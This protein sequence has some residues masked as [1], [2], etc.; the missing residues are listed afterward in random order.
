[1][2]FAKITGFDCGGTAV[3]TAIKFIIGVLDVIFVLLPILL[4]LLLVID[5]IKNIVA[6][7]EDEMKKNKNLLIKRIIVCVILF[8]VEPITHFVINN[9]A[10][11]EDNYLACIKIAKETDDL[12]QYEI[13]VPEVE[14]KE[15]YSFFDNKKKIVAPK[16]E[17]KKEEQTGGEEDTDTS[18]A[19]SGSSTFDKITQNE[20]EVKKAKDK[21]ISKKT[22][23][24]LTEKKINNK[25]ISVF[26]IKITDASQLGQIQA[27]DKYGSGV[28]TITSMV[29]RKTSK[30]S[31]KKVILAVTGAFFKTSNGAQ[32]IA[33]FKNNFGTTDGIVIQN[34]K[35]V[36]DN[37]SKKAWGYE[38]CQDN[39][40]RLFYAKKGESAESLIKKGVMNTF[41]SHEARGIDN[42]KYIEPDSADNNRAYARSY[43]A[44][45]KPGEYYVVQ[46][47]YDVTRA[48]ALS[49]IKD[50]LKCS[51][52][53][54]LE[55]GGA[56]ASVTINKTIKYHS[57]YTSGIG[58]A[59]VITE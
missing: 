53:G 59:F 45:K 48:E 52:A 34:G 31:G 3:L 6:G 42:G 2:S 36:E 14:N 55:Q 37:G 33:A 27:N 8:L 57:G 58:D 43:L 10:A 12:S 7:S 21:Y 40:G 23:M 24:V 47:G 35:L 28:E 1:M 20:K 50:K 41:A 4:T 39:K 11:K 18:S 13:K 17:E 38:I 9:A 56:V 16:K 32:N 25:T 22:Y 51:F 54:S 29:K 19:D 5:I 30:S 49:Y 46:I 26:H 15:K 44:M